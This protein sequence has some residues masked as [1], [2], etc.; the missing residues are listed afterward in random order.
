MLASFGTVASMPRLRAGLGG[1]LLSIAPPLASPAHAQTCPDATDPCG[2]PDDRDYSSHI[3]VEPPLPTGGAG[4]GLFPQDFDCVNRLGVAVACEDNL[5]LGAGMAQ[6]IAFTESTAGVF[7]AEGFGDYCDVDD[8]V[9]P[10]GTA[11]GWLNG[12][13]ASLSEPWR[14]AMHSGSDQLA[15]PYLPKVGGWPSA[16]VQMGLDTPPDDY[17]SWLGPGP[18]AWSGNTMQTAQVPVGMF[19]AH[20]SMGDDAAMPDA[21]TAGV[22]TPPGSGTDDLFLF[23][24][25]LEAM[26]A[27]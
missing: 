6:Y 2:C 8:T 26:C 9:P 20:A 24:G 5:A 17:D 27:F 18:Y 21:L 7:A 22:F 13:N 10:Q 1:L 16:F 25:Y 11:A 23:E 14:V 12:T 15:S 3:P 4:Y 19:G